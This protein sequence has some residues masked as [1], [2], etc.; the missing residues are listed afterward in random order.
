[1]AV[2]ALS[3]TAWAEDPPALR[4]E[5]NP[6]DVASLS[7]E[8]LLNPEVQS[9]SKLTQKTQEAPSVVSVI[10]KEQRE[11]FGWYTLNDILFKQPGF[12]PSQ[13]YERVTVGSRGLWE[14]WNSNHLL[15]LIDGVPYNDNETGGAYTWELTP[16]FLAKTVEI[17]RGPGSALYGSSA[18]NGVIALQTPSPEPGKLEGLARSRIGD[19]G[20]QVHDVAVSGATGSLGATVGFNSSRTFGNEYLSYDG[21]GRTDADGNLQKFRVHDHRSSTYLFAKLEALAPGFKGLSL[22]LHRQAWDYQTGHGWLFW[23][24][25][26]FE[27]QQESRHIV[28]GAWRP[29]GFGDWRP[30]VVLRYQR[31]DVHHDLRWYPNDA[32]DGFYPAGV[33]EVIVSHFDDLFARAQLTRTLPREVSVMAGVEYDAFLYNGDEA[34]HATA[35]LLNYADG[36]PPLPGPTPLGPYYEW[37]DGQPVHHLGVY[38]QLSSGKLL[39]EKL[40]LTAGLRYDNQF[41]Q[42]HDLSQDARPLTAKSFDAFSPRLALVF[43]P[44]ERLSIKAMAG[45]AFRAPAP[46]E[47]FGANT[48]AVGSN[49]LE[50]RPEQISTLELAADWTVTPNLTWRTNLFANRFENQI[51]YSPTLV[52]V[53]YYS[54]GLLGGET[55]LLTRASLG[56]GSLSGFANYSYAALLDEAVLTAGIDPTGLLTWAPA[57]SAKAGVGYERGPLQASAQLL[58]QGEVLRRPSDVV[59][60]E[61]AALRPASAPAFAT[62]DLNLGYRPVRW[63]KVGVQVNN[64]ADAR[65]LLVKG[66][67]YPFDYQIVG[68]RVQAVV[69]LNP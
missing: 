40:Q 64:L 43:S 61:N 15:L 63:F 52:L 39:T 36:N 34:H 55:E 62:V 6:L 69:E 2:A 45:R 44:L 67:D 37:I 60:P 20:T 57:H 27:Q 1:V 12:F 14:S 19:W 31:H 13:D 46:L 11:L 53:N 10:S 47:L 17:I 8:D 5:D 4:P 51:A 16:L 32:F 65:G 22:Q 18:T 35:D 59:L 54:R 58:F 9:A 42:F 41:F 38:L 28:T 50:L 29:E 26:T 3:I 24:P 66:G 23:S 68:R 30:E 49:L 56:G 33:N 25:D 21:S 48:W 7:L